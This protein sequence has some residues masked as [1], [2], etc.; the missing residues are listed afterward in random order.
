MAVMK[1]AMKGASA[2]A[3]FMAEW[4]TPRLAGPVIAAAA[5]RLALLAAAWPLRCRRRDGFSFRGSCSTQAE[6]S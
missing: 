6:A 2:S 3:G 4:W 1:I 5:L